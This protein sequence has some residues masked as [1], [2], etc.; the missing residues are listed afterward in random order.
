MSKIISRGMEGAAF[1]GIMGTALGTIFTGITLAIPG[2]NIVVTPLLAAATV[3][4]AATVT[5]SG[6]ALGTVTVVSV[7]GAA[8]FSYYP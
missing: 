8:V 6:G 2:V 7:M 4:T 5:V 3:A 1:G